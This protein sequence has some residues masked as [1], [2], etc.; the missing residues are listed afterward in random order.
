MQVKQVNRESPQ[1]QPR[2][3]RRRRRLSLWQ[4]MAPSPRP[5]PAQRRRYIQDG[6]LH[7]VRDASLVFELSQ[8]LTAWRLV[9][10][11]NPWS[12]IWR[13]YQGCFPVLLA[14]GET[15]ASGSMHPIRWLPPHKKTKSNK[16]WPGFALEPGEGAWVCLHYYVIIW[17][18]W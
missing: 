6:C 5:R 17:V 12:Y 16:G 4:P 10:S 14:H 7:D 11:M 1:R 2:H 9:L 15:P 3:R 8:F 18:A 13:V